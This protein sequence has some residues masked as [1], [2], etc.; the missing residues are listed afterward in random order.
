MSSHLAHS[1]ESSPLMIW[2]DLYGPDNT[3]PITLNNQEE[4][5]ETGKGFVR[6]KPDN[7]WSALFALS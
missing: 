6:S 5:R 4:D 3:V 7:I 2:T 1:P